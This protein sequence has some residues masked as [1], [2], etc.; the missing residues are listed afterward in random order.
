MKLHII[1]VDDLALTAGVTRGIID[2]PLRGIATSTRALMSSPSVASNLAQAGAMA[3]NLGFGVH[4]ALTKGKPVLPA[5]E[6]PNLTDNF[7]CFY[8]L[9]ALRANLVPLDLDEVK[10]EWQA[11]I[12]AFTAGGFLPHHLD[13]H[14]HISYSN[15]SL[16]SVMLEPAHQ[17]GLPVRYL[18]LTETQI[19]NNE[20][21]G[22]W[23]E[24][25]PIRRSQTCIT[26]FYGIKRVWGCWQI[27]SPT[28]LK[29]SAN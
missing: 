15:A 18:T 3:P 29:A 23:F 4:L 20:T 25:L 2:A 26:T 7:G 5:T 14:H 11:Q 28:C 6:V 24:K 13:S 16:L 12:E 27:F 19:L 9:D 17:H 1:N 8:P 22:E 21:A 10:K